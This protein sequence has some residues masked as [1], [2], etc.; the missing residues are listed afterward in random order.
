MIQR[1]NGYVTQRMFAAVQAFSSWPTRARNYPAPLRPTWFAVKYPVSSMVESQTS[2]TDWAVLIAAIAQRR[3]RVAFGRLF[4]YFAPRVKAYMKRGGLGE[5]AA[6]E[7]AQETLLAVWRKAVLFD[8]AG[9][10]ASGWVFTIARNLRIDLARREGRR[11][12]G[13]L[14]QVE[15]EFILDSPVLPDS[16][17]VARQSQ[18]RVQQALA[19]L[20]E[21]QRRVI[22]LSYY[23]EKAHP[24]IA[25]LL[26]IPL[27]TVKSR[28]RLAVARLRHLLDETT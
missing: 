17:A 27:G 28:L 24:E 14:K 25:Q 5:G 7:L 13:A 15:A 16:Q 10:S 9:L 18:K 26:G 2:D 12:A 20:S 21:E 1:P 3:D 22:E 6:E 4:Q 11:Q 23:E 8:P 19:A